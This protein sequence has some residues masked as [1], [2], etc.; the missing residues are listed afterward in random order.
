[1]V[2]RS[3]KQC[4]VYSAS[5]LK[6]TKTC[7]NKIYVCS[8]RLLFNTVSINAYSLFLASFYLENTDF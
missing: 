3:V 5:G 1:M 7:V 4:A 6:N 8:P 2:K